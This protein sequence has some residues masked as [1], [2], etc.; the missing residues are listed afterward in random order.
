MQQD[1]GLEFVFDHVLISFQF[2]NLTPKYFRCETRTD[3]AEIMYVR[4]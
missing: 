3:A 1:K 2:F 4:K